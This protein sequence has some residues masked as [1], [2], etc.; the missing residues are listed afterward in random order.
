MGIRERATKGL[1]SEV[2]CS[3]AW[4]QVASTLSTPS[5]TAWNAFLLPVIIMQ[6]ES[7]RTDTIGLLFRQ[8]RYTVDCGRTRI[9]SLPV[10]PLH[11]L[12]PRQLISGLTASAVTG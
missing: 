8:L 3:R 10:L 12:F 6:K 11:L 9:I 1:L 4:S 5:V 7:L 2:I